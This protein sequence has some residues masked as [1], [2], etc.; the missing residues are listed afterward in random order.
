MTSKIAGTPV[1]GRAVQ[2]FLRLC[3]R[4]CPFVS[5]EYKPSVIRCCC[6]DGLPS[7]HA[8]KVGDLNSSR[9]HTKKSDNGKDRQ[10]RQA[11]LCSSSINGGWT[12]VGVWSLDRKSTTTGWARRACISSMH[13]L[14][15][16]STKGPLLAL[17]CP[18]CL[19][20][21]IFVVVLCIFLHKHW[22]PSNHVN[23]RTK[24]YYGADYFI[25][26]GAMLMVKLM[27]NDHQQSLKTA[28]A[29]SFGSGVSSL[30]CE[31]A[32]AESATLSA[33]NWRTLLST[34]ESLKMKRHC[35]TVQ[36]LWHWNLN[37]NCNHLH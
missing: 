21:L 18:T 13:L 1:P 16:E 10:R 31:C 22:S 35:F 12:R 23:F 20:C 6:C 34:I 17:P 3:L 24:Y 33:M 30:P 7:T 4:A 32:N 15:L 2:N 5:R 14:E 8:Y 37:K 19:L 27:F 11:Y 26:F 36:H 25:T 29:F 9:M 28:T